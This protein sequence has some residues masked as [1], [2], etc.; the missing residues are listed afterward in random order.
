[1]ALSAPEGL[2]LVGEYG[3]AEQWIADLV[4][5]RRDGQPSV[6]VVNAG[7]LPHPIDGSATLAFVARAGTAKLAN[8]RRDPRATLLFRSGWEWVAVRGTAQLAG[9][10]DPLTGIGPDRLRRLLRDTYQAAGGHHPDMSEYDR[11]MAVER[12]VAV[13]VHP[14]RLTTNPVGAE[15]QEHG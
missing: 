8:L 3:G 10:D 14:S 15:H 1:M 5:L 6:C 4:T 11:V 9:P 13:L 12:R 7:V 2:R